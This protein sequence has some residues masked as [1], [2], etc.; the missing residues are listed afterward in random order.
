MSQ[1]KH[2]FIK[3]YRRRAQTRRIQLHVF[4]I[5]PDK[6][7]DCIIHTQRKRRLFQTDIQ[8]FGKQKLRV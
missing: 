6:D 7:V 5:P 1:Q 8:Q 3:M 2:V 4:E